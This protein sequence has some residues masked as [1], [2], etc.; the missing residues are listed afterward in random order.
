MGKRTY[1]EHASWI[2]VKPELTERQEN[3][4]WT[5]LANVPG[6][7]GFLKGGWLQ[8]LRLSVVAQPPP[9]G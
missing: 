8:T 4:Q 1:M 7:A 2:P 3:V 9:F 5:Y 6:R